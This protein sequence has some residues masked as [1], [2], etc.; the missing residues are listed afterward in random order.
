MFD[1]TP[2]KKAEKLCEA[3]QEAGTGEVTEPLDKQ[4]MPHGQWLRSADAQL[5]AGL[6]PN[7]LFFRS[8]NGQTLDPDAGEHAARATGSKG[9]PLPA[10]LR[11]RFE[12]STGADLSG[13]RVHTGAESQVA[14]QSLGAR[15]YA[16]GK[17][18]HFNA[19]Q[20]RPASPEGQFLLAHE[21]MHTM[22]QGAAGSQGTQAKMEVS[23]R[24]DAVEDEADRGAIGLLTG[25]PVQV[26]AATGLHRT[27]LSDDMQSAA[28]QAQADTRQQQL[29][30]PTFIGQLTTIGDTS[31]AQRVHNDIVGYRNNMSQGMADGTVTGAQIAA[32]EAAVQTLSSY[33]D[34]AGVQSGSLGNFQSSFDALMQN[35]TRLTAQVNTL[36]PNIMQ[37]EGPNGQP[38]TDAQRGD[39]IIEA[40]GAD[41]QTLQRDF[42]S[43]VTGN[44]ATN[45]P[46]QQTQS[47]DVLRQM[48][49][50]ASEVGRKQSALSGKD[51]AARSAAARLVSTL[52]QQQADGI[53]GQIDGLKSAAS[54]AKDQISSIAGYIK[55]AIKTVSSP[56]TGIAAGA[57]LAVSTVADIAG[58]A[59]SHQYDQQIATLQSQLAPIRGQ[60]NAANVDAAI[61]AST[62]AKR[63]LVEAGQALANEVQNQQRL[64][65][66]YR[67][68]MRQMG[69]A[70]DSTRGAG[71]NA[72]TIVAQ[73]LAE[74]ETYLAQ[75][76]ATMQLAQA[77]QN[78]AGEARTR[79]AGVNRPGANGHNQGMTYYRPYQTLV[80]GQFRVSWGAGEMS[81]HL[82]LGVD[83]HHT[84]SAEG[85]RSG[86]NPA[87]QRALTELQQR[88]TRVNSMAERL[89]V[90][91][92]T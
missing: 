73:V 44:R 17:D 64:Q 66:Q 84:G 7:S 86:V 89:R 71:A 28:N 39:A 48:Q 2:E 60:I 20:Y 61:N 3:Q 67:E 19:D 55:T 56:P 78:D 92:R 5:A 25:G 62:A 57:E 79:A 27:D 83:D 38:M 70:V 41:A 65:A 69:Q 35:Y 24:G 54:A 16:Q 87:I 32:N 51:F 9:D 18:I 58:Y 40:S 1:V 34:A 76:T 88:H 82:L 42:R 11:S 30:H 91:F 8:P 6:S 74:C 80:P 4:V 47:R 14:A 13:V 46:A 36:D 31:Q 75:S 37:A 52:S 26:R 63:E 45:A 53:Q 59:A 77:E 68:S 85:Q 43:A 33:L 49:N 15:A 21:V 81:F 29:E 23:A 22:Q 72:T 12:S 10:D 90:V 50:S